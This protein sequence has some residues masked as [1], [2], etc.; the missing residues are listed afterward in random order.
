MEHGNFFKIQENFCEINR[1][2]IY[3]CHFCRNTGLNFRSNTKECFDRCFQKK[4]CFLEK[5][6][7]KQ[8]PCCLDSFFF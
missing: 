2:H 8:V 1:Q 5:V 3:V 7:L 4:I 6:S